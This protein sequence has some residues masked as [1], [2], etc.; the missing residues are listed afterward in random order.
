IP[1]LRGIT[2]RAKRVRVKAL[3]REL[4]PLVIETAG[5]FARVLQHECDHLDG[6]VYMDRMRD[7]SSLTYLQE[8]ERYGPPGDDE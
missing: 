2:P 5:F 1:D 6:R 3:D 4:K 7:L 8:M